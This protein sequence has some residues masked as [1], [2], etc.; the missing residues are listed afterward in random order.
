MRKLGASPLR[1]ELFYLNC[2]INDGEFEIEEMERRWEEGG[3]ICCP[4]C[5]FGGGY[6]DLLDKQL[7]R[8]VRRQYIWDKLGI[9]R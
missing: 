6:Y 5:M 3:R 1:V 2:N 8:R 9:I 4:N 7:R